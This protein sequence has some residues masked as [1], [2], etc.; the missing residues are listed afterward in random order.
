MSDERRKHEI[1]KRISKQELQRR[2]EA[3]R[4]A[5][6]KE[7]LDCLIM[8]NNNQFL[9]GY[10][11]YFTDIPAMFSY[12]MTVIFPLNEDMITISHGGSPFPTPPV[13]Y[14]FKERISL[15][16]LPTLTRTNDM[17]AKAAVETLKKLKVKSLGVVAPA[18]MCAFMYNYIK[19]SLP[20][21]D[22]KYATDLVDE[23]KAIKSEEE[24]EII[25]QT[26]EMQDIV[27][28]GVLAIV[29]PGVREYEIRSEIQR[30]CCNWGSEEQLIA[31]GAG[32]AGTPVMQGSTSGG[33]RVL[34]E[35]DQVCIM[36]EV[37]GS[38][39]FYCE[40]G[41]T[42]C[43]GDAPKPLL[44]LW[45]FVVK[46]QDETAKMLKPGAE[47]AKLFKYYNDELAKRGCT[48]DLRLFCHG[49]GY[50]L[51]E[52]PSMRPE[53]D[54][55]VRANMNI[56]V[57]PMTINAEKTAYAFCCDNYIVGDSGAYRIHKTP[58]KV[59]VV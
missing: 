38:G 10:T 30:L 28:G 27:W 58:R 12:T 1:G 11:R 46:L 26:A 51:V 40:L 43:I 6:E 47:P 18:F 4:K 9:G 54:M 35:G 34:Q 44:D 22:I 41:R 32:P 37:N 24:L 13:T 5:M 23:I 42:V 53:E 7:K 17:D 52:R 55:M 56:A 16:Y 2:W 25:K 15:P 19:E 59:F 50:D 8:Q 36:P 57:H 33:N 45:D 20:D 39:G 3:V 31:V 21:M 49:Q 14:G 29:R 48:S